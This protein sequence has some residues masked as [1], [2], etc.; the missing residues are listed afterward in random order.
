[1]GS[2]GETG[3]GPGAGSYGP[4]ENNGLAHETE[5]DS[6]AQPFEFIDQGIS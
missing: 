5:A 2:R 4:R 1:M 3:P 6:R